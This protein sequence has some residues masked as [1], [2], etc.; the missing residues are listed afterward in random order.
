MSVGKRLRDARKAK[1]LTQKELAGMIAVKHNSVSN[2]ENDQNK[3]DLDTI[4]RI[5]SVL[6]ISSAYLL[7]GE[8]VPATSCSDELNRALSD[9]EFAL[10]DAVRHLTDEDKEDILEFVRFKAEQKEKRKRP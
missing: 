3:P 2:W 7:E 9:T 4:R 10:F 1:G 6:D 5:C 8:A